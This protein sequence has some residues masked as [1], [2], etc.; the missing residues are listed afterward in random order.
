[1][2]RTMSKAER[3][4]YLATLTPEQRAAAEAA[5]LAAMSPEERMMLAEAAEA[6]DREAKLQGDM[7]KAGMRK[8]GDIMKAWLAGSI[9]GYLFNWA[10]QVKTEKEDARNAKDNAKKT[11]EQHRA[12]KKL[13]KVFDKWMAGTLRGKLFAWRQNNM[14]DTSKEDAAREEA[15]K[16]KA[17]GYF[18]NSKMTGAWNGWRFSY[19]EIC[20]QRDLLMRSIKRAQNTKLWACL[21]HWLSRTDFSGCKRPVRVRLVV[22]DQMLKGGGRPGKWVTRGNKYGI[23]F[24][25]VSKPQMNS[26]EAASST[27]KTMEADDL[28]APRLGARRSMRSTSPSPTG[29][30]SSS[31]KR[32]RPKEFNTKIQLLKATDSTL[33]VAWMIPRFNSSQTHTLYIRQLGQNATEFKPIAFLDP[34]ADGKKGELTYLVTHLRSLQKYELR[35]DIGAHNRACDGI[36][37][38]AMAPK[39]S[40]VVQSRTSPKKS[41]TRSGSSMFPSRR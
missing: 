31:P 25:K 6:A 19:S 5:M 41:P 24:A 38:T 18:K 36:F 10:F 2:L 39:G 17:A 34:K 21:G 15:A 22:Q 26:Y 29:H 1:M 27:C 37:G 33:M 11:A 9:R 4:A 8:M 20:R 32:E 23:A 35:V 3:E 12:M 28:S 13:G 16:R 40:A 30:V 7:K 14:E